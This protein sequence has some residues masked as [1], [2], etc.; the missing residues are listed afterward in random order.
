MDLRTMTATPLKLKRLR[1]TRDLGGMRTADG[2]TVA[3]GKLLRSGKLSK[4]PKRSVEGLLALGLTTVVDLRIRSER[5]A[6]PDTVIE[7]VRTFCIPFLATPLPTDGD[8]RAISQR[9]Y[10]RAKKEGERIKKEFGSLDNYMIETYRDLLFRADSQEGLKKFLRLVEEEEGCILW[11]C[12]SGK[13]R[14]GICAMLVESLLGVDEKSILD[15]YMMSK[16]IWRARYFV[17]RA[18]IAVGPIPM[19]LKRALFG[20]MRLKRKYLLTVIEDMK[21][22]YGSVIGYCKDALGVTDESIRRLREKYLL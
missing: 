21:Q 3:S 17:N 4:L 15:D 20:F 2:R 19:S 10:A 13:D 8:V 11:H 18:V 22:T 9:E 12:A 7:G 6:S 5:E 1:N 14:T 16:R